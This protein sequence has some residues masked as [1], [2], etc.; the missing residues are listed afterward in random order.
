[1]GI[2]LSYALICGV[3]WYAGGPKGAVLAAIILTI[4]WA[5]SAISNR[6]MQAGTTPA[7]RERHKQD[8]NGHI[9][10]A[11][12][13]KTIHEYDGCADRFRRDFK[14]RIGTEL[15]GRCE[16]CSFN[17]TQDGDEA[18]KDIPRGK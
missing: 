13:G 11:R 12:N 10:Y 18:E 8:G 14:V 9:Y 17:G 16:Q 2:F 4:L 7:D 1:M 6:H 3:A 5:I 15:A